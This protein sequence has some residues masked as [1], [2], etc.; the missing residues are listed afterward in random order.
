MYSVWQFVR[1]PVVKK[2][3]KK[4]GIFSFS[5][6]ALLHGG[7]NLTHHMRATNNTTV[8][9]EQV[10]VFT[11][12]TM[13]ALQQSNQ[14][15][16]ARRHVQNQQLPIFAPDR[17]DLTRMRIGYATF[18]PTALGRCCIKAAVRNSMNFWDLNFRIGYPR[19]H[20]IYD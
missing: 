17:S 1:G 14:N 20:Y 6:G 10:I 4:R 18:G 5:H 8:M 19:T 3:G 9:N 13:L 12:A 11:A 7:Y 15:S 16:L 2:R